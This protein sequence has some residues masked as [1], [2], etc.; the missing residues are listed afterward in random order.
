MHELCIRGPAFDQVT[1]MSKFLYLGMGLA[2]VVERSTVTAAAALGRPELG[3]LT[4]GTPGDAAILSVDEG[5]Y[6]FEDVRGVVER[7]TRKIN[8]RGVVQNGAFID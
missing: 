3:T 1:T 6:A 5:D 8:A 2:E 7:G 4:P